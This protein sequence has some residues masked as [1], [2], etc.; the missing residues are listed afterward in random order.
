MAKIQLQSVESV[1]GQRMMACWEPVLGGRMQCMVRDIFLLFG[2]GRGKVH[3]ISNKIH[4]KKG[5]IL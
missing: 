4:I 5:K 3:K 1:D 2:Q